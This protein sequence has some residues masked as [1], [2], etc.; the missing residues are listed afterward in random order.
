MSTSRSTVAEIIEHLREQAEAN[1]PQTVGSIREYGTMLM[2]EVR[3]RPVRFEISTLDADEA[4]SALQE[5][6][7]ENA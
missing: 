2:V 4:W 5:L 6:I 1:Y 3:S 7:E